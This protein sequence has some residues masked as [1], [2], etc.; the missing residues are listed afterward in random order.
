M[1]PLVV[2]RLLIS[3]SMYIPLVNFD[4]VVYY[5]LPALAVWSSYS[6]Y[7]Q[8]DI[9][10][11]QGH[12]HC[13]GMAKDILETR[14]HQIHP[15]VRYAPLGGRVRS[16]LTAV[17]SG[18]RKFVCSFSPRTLRPYDSTNDPLAKEPGLFFVFRRPRRGGGGKA[19]VAPGARTSRVTG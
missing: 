16:E 13:K 17:M 10:F 11:S 9:M 14:R 5:R 3:W 4:L 7:N 1:C 12:T 19:L 2:C 8:S 6:L 15:P 18:R